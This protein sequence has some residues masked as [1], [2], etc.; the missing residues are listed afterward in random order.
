MDI[1]ALVTGLIA[2]LQQAPAFVDAVE[3]FWNSIHSASHPKAA[4]ATA[5]ATQH[6]NNMRREIA[7][8][9][10][11]NQAEQAEKDPAAKAADEREEEVDE[12]T[13]DNGDGGDSDKK[14]DKRR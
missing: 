10:S 8:A 14:S 5:A 6:D 4:A 7:N 12:K 1:S 2:L 9:R 13:S 11:K 3:R